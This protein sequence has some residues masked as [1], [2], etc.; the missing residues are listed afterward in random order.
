MKNV[1]ENKILVEN[2]KANFDYFFEEKIEAGIVLE[3][4]EV[5]SIL[6]GRAQL[7]DAFIY[8]KEQEAFL[9]NLNVTPLVTVNT[10]K[11]VEKER[12]KKLLLHKKE[13]NRFSGLVSRDGYTCVP[14]NIHYANGKIKL[15]IGVAKGKKQHDKRQTIKERD[16]SRDIRKQ[17]FWFLTK[18]RSVCLDMALQEKMLGV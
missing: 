5:K 8:F 11:K 3:G 17:N 12:V 14:L 6:S 1:I 18:R 9:L 2:R 13:I 4:W 10:H 16:L 7:S 15:L